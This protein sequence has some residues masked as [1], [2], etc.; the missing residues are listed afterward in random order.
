MTTT[1]WWGWECN[2][3]HG[4][5]WSVCLFGIGFFRTWLFNLALFPNY[6]SNIWFYQVRRESRLGR[7]RHCRGRHESL[8]RRRAIVVVGVLLREEGSLNGNPRH[9]VLHRHGRQ[10]RF[11]ILP[12][13]VPGPGRVRAKSRVSMRVIVD[14]P[15]C[16]S[17]S[18]CLCGK[19]SVTQ[20]GSIR[21]CNIII[22][23]L[24]VLQHHHYCTSR[25]SLER[26]E[27]ILSPSPRPAIILG[28]IWLF[29][30]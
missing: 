23:A 22:T 7:W 21:C 27:R 30:S 16:S 13:S 9:A 5:F 17:S 11:R 12:W 3:R 2:L 29:I 18:A 19:C 28:S 1:K 14:A 24:A 25:L 4:L 6:V 8:H 20:I 10:V 26:K 15:M